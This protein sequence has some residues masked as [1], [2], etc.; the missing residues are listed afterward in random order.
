MDTAGQLLAHKTSQDVCT[1]SPDAWVFDAIKILADH[2]LG[3]LIVTDRDRLVGVFTERDYA[4]KI[5]LKGRSSRTTKVRDI[6]SDRVIYVTLETPLEECMA[7]MLNK[8]IRH[9]PVLAGDRLAGIVSMGDA[10]KACLG[11][12]QFMIDQLVH[13]I[14]GSAVVPHTEAHV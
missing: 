10:I 14:T 13:Y 7:L 2:N 12:R 9:L 5:I 6:M 11:E 1:I 4:R 3:A 8:Y